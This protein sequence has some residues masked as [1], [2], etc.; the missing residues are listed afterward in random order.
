M[1]IGIEL[2]IEIIINEIGWRVENVFRRKKR[3]VL[4][5]RENGIIEGEIE[6]IGFGW[7]REIKEGMGKW[8]IKIRREKIIIGIIGR[9]EDGKR[10]R[11]GKE[12]IIKRNK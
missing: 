10:M 8:K 1:V 2:D 11:I 3:K 4:F 12:D 6:R 7:S 5:W 9:V